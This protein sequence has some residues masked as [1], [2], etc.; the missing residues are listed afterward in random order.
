MA[1]ILEQV[2]KLLTVA[3]PDL[4]LV[5]GDTTTAFAAALATFYLR[6]PVA[7]IEAGLRTGCLYSPW[8]EEAHRCLIDRLTSYFFAPTLQAQNTLIT[9]GVSPKKGCW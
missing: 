6:I 7:H 8:P 3:K 4:V 5:Q 1:Y 9:E 2:S